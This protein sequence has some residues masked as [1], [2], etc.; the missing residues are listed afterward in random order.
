MKKLTVLVEISIADNISEVYPNYSLNY[1]DE[2][3]FIDSLIGDIET[4]YEFEGLPFDNLKQYGYST[5]V[6]F[7]DEAKLIDL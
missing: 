4:P 7:R 1:D 2:E 3:Q 5:R 6:L